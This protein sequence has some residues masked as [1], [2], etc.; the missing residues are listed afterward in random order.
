MTNFF[1]SWCGPQADEQV[2]KHVASLLVS[3]DDAGGIAEVVKTLPLAYARTE[4]LKRIAERHGKKGVAGLLS[5]KVPKKQSARSGDLGEILGTAYVESS[6]GFTTG[7][8]RLIE[9]DHQEWAM[10]GDDVLG[11]RVVNQKVEL[12][13][14]EAKSRAKA[15]KTVIREARDGLSRD[16]DLAS[17]HS[18]TQF[19]E[20]LLDE[21]G[22]L[23]EAVNDLLLNDGLRPNRLVHVMFLFVGNNPITHIRSDLTAYSGTVVQRTVTIRVATHQN[24]IRTS[25]DTVLRDA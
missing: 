22:P 16:G 6:L 15:G 11:A 17:A 25:F 10:R 23:N 5:N 13:K 20:R 21:H 24:F 1:A 8:S 18:L 7:P 9:R 14:V 12:V 2:G 3:N 4:N 19:A